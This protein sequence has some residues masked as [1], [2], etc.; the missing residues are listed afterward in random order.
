MDLTFDP[1]CAVSGISY[2]P[3]YT[4]PRDPGPLFSGRGLKDL[5][6]HYDLTVRAPFTLDD[7]MTRNRIWTALFGTISL[8]SRED[9]AV[10]KYDGVLDKYITSP[11]P[12]LEEAIR[13]TLKRAKGK[14]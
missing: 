5:P 10:A 1:S 13:T 8:P 2:Q 4:L 9:G 14:E 7:S 12:S 3:D 6:A 11:G